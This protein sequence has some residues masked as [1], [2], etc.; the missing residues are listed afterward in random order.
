VEI[1]KFIAETQKPPG[2]FTHREGLMCRMLLLGE[3]TQERVDYPGLYI[4]QTHYMYQPKKGKETFHT[5]YGLHVTP[6]SMSDNRFY[7]Q[8]E[9]VVSSPLVGK[10]ELTEE[11]EVTVL[12]LN[13]SDSDAGVESWLQVDADFTLP[14][15][16]NPERA[17]T[18]GGVAIKQFPIDTRW[19]K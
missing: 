19:L 14:K 6:K 18:F 3:V 13:V 16:V 12:P 5:F 4:A 7:Q 11:D 15:G 10:G 1:T 2:S 8:I 17:H 9:P